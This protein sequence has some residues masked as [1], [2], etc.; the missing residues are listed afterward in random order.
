MGYFCVTVGTVNEEI[1]RN[2]IAK[3]FNEHENDVFC[4]E[5]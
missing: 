1:I 2:Y 4:I 5:E 3:Q